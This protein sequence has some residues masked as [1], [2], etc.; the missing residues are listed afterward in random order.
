MYVLSVGRSREE[1]RESSNRNCYS[2]QRHATRQ[3]RAVL[4]SSAEKA[5]SVM[6]G[7]TNTERIMPFYC[8]SAFQWERVF[9]YTEAT[10]VTNSQRF[11]SRNLASLRPE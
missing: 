2:F 11:H 3:A 10:F 9:A 4:R 8:A 7:A 1:G 5:Q 6:K